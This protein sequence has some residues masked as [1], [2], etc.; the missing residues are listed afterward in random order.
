MAWH[1]SGWNGRVCADPA[2]NTYCTGSH[3]LLSERLAR[4]KS[5]EREKAGEKLDAGLPEYL[6][7]CFWTSCVFATDETKTVHRHPFGYLKDQKKVDGALPANSVY[8]WPFRLSITH[9][10]Y[11]RHGQYFPDL[12]ERID[13]Y[14][15]RLTKGSSLIFFYLNSLVSQEG[16]VAVSYLIDTA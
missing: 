2:G 8:T 6:P 16:C 10:S 13:R 7:P 14:C 9:N 11:N 1:D 4:E 12:E 5:T 15:E 3:S